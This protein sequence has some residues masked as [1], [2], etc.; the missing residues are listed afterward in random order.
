MIIQYYRYAPGPKFDYTS[1]YL[2]ESR[3]IGA[4]ALYPN[5]CEWMVPGTCDPDNPAEIKQ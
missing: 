3:E 2:L 5:E 4:W 1:V